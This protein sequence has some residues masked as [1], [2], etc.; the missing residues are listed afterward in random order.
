AGDLIIPGDYLEVV[1]EL[2]TPDGF[3]IGSPREKMDLIDST[4]LP[5]EDEL[6]LD[7]PAHSTDVVDDYC[8]AIKKIPLLTAS[9]EVEFATRIEAG[10]YAGL[11]L[12]L[13]SLA[14]DKRE[15]RLAELR[16]PVGG[17][18]K[19]SQ[20]V[21]QRPESLVNDIMRRV[22]WL[23]KLSSSDKTEVM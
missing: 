11:L 20:A 17:G 4:T 2:P 1:E 19:E 6:D 3:A 23:K 10:L 9:E 14:D 22:I 7:E 16:H 12:E 15:E 18:G 21:R 13:C 5:K 8:S